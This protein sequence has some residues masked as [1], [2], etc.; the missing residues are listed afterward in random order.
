MGINTIML[1]KRVFICAFSEDIS[2]IV[3][4]AIEGPH[5]EKMPVSCLQTHKNAMFIL[6]AAAAEKLTRFACPWTINGA[7]GSF[8]A[9][10]D[11]LMVKKAVAWLSKKTKKFILSLEED[12]YRENGL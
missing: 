12:D 10:Y 2:D 4:N 6:D 3:Y 5:T 1:A 11:L 8:E 9:E 7:N